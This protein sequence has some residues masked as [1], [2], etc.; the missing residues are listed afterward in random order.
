MKYS[1]N[2]LE[3]IYAIIEAL[4]KPI[5][6]FDFL[7]GELGY[8]TL[9]SQSV[10]HKFY[11]EQN[12]PVVVLCWHG[13]SILFSNVSA[14]QIEYTND[15]VALRG[16]DIHRGEPRYE[17]LVSHNHK[18]RIDTIPGIVAHMGPMY[19]T[20]GNVYAKRLRP[21]E[22]IDY[23]A[24]ITT[25]FFGLYEY[26]VRY[27]EQEPP[28]FISPCTIPIDGPYIAFFDRNEKHQPERNAQDWH[29]KLLQRWAKDY[30]YKLVVISGLYLRKI[31]GAIQFAPK[32]RDLD[33]LC[34]VAQG[35]TAFFS[36]PGGASE[37]AMMFGCNFGLLGWLPPNFTVGYRQSV[38]AC[39]HKYFGEL[40]SEDS[41]YVAETEKFLWMM[42]S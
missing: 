42:Q 23:L 19:W 15:D 32:H 12:V 37:A 6:I 38:E 28:T 8:E 10:A 21:D 40:D 36:S 13:C 1:A 16:N 24:P 14:I 5:A 29:V 22:Y 7:C 9:C 41:N 30:G 2:S 20:G 35:S 27:Y 39:G 26:I 33:L 3:E 34:A 25:N 4:P 11:K 18:E 31:E 17:W